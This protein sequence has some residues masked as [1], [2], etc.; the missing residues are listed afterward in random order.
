MLTADIYKTFRNGVRVRVL[1]KIESS[2]RVT[3]LFGPS[4]AGKTTVLRCIAGL[5]PLTEG[6]ITLG[7]H[8][9]TDVARGVY[10]PPQR[11]PV[12]YLFQDYALFPTCRWRR[13]SATV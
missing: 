1:L 4:G 3:V 13:T 2:T 8:V 9:W 11:R 5:E 12:G 7:E 6:K 10:L